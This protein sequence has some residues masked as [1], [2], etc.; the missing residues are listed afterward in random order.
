MPRKNNDHI[1]RRVG[2][3]IIELRLSMGLSRLQLANEIGVTHQQLQKYEKGTNRITA[4]RLSAIANALKKPVSYFFEEFE[5]KD[6]LPDQHRRM[7][8]EVSRNFL[9]IKNPMHQNA[10]NLLVRTLSEC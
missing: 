9:R 1:D 7:C 10:V 3:K 5:E 2:I 4:G 8:I 6:A